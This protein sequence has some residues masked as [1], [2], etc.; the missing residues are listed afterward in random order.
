[1]RLKWSPLAVN[2]K[3]DDAHA[4]VEKIVTPL[5]A[6]AEAVELTLDIPK[7]PDYMKHTLAGLD[8]EL[9]YSASRIQYKISSCRTQLPKEVLAK[10]QH[11]RQL[12]RRLEAS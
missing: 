12:E 4:E 6:A 7:L 11:T 10:E 8:R 9:R 3:L 2:D 5:Q 1:M